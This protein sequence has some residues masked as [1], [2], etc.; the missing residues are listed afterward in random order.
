MTHCACASIMVVELNPLAQWSATTAQVTIS[1][2]HPA[3][4]GLVAV[5]CTLAPAPRPDTSS[6][7]NGSWLLPG[8][9]V[10]IQTRPRRLISPITPGI[11]HP[12]KVVRLTP[13]KLLWKHR[14]LPAL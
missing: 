3:Q 12:R 6:V 5:T 10:V 14:L 4:I 8:S 13:C 11:V 9:T 1:A 2:C 7:C